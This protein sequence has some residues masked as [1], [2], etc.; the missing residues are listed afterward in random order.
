MTAP[1]TPETPA[2]PEAEPGKAVAKRGFLGTLPPQLQ[3]AFQLRQAEAQMFAEVSKQSWGNNLDR[4]QRRALAA[5]CQRNNLDPSMIDLLGNK[6]YR[7]ASFYLDRLAKLIASGIVEY[8]VADYITLDPR[9]DRIAA[10]Q[11]DPKRAEQYRVEKNRRE[12]E[13]VRWGVPD[14]A[15]AACVFRVKLKGVQEIAGCKPVTGNNDPVGK[16]N[17]VATA[18]TR[19]A[20]RCLR[21]LVEISPEVKQLFEQVEV[22]WGQIAATVQVGDVEDAETPATV[23]LPGGAAFRGAGPA[24]KPLASGGYGEPTPAEPVAATPAREPG[25]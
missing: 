14:E 20:R 5:F 12:D 2:T 24:V 16:G 6:L 4:D 15:L 11:S 18:E 3:A 10:D 7:N 25:D 8:A 13:R 17:P 23:M 9:I 21:K 1:T 19:S 22:E